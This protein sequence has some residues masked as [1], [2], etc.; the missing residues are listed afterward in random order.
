MLGTNRA[1]DLRKNPTEA[2]KRLWKHLRHRQLDGYKFYRQF[3]FPP[4][5]ADFLCREG[6]L[7][8]EVDGGQHA[9]D[10]AYDQERTRYMERHGYTVLRFWNNEVLSNTEGV[11]MI[12]AQKLKALT[13]ALSLKGEGE[14]DMRDGKALSLQGEGLGEGL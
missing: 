2:E 5:F 9:E 1:R 3:P 14:D 12:V 11:L 6:K 4:Y 13:P 7:V 10:A 8:V